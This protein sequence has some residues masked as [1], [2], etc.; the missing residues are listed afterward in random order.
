M[1]HLSFNSRR[2]TPGIVRF[3]FCCIFLFVLAALSSCNVKDDPDSLLRTQFAPE[4]MDSSH[5][6]SPKTYS[7]LHNI[8]PPLGVKPVIVAVEKIEEAEMGTY[9]DNLFDRFCEKEYSGNTF[10]Q[11][12]VLIVASKEPELIQVRVG[13][14]YAVYCRMRGS[15]AGAD[16]LAMQKETAARGIDEMCPVALKNV[17]E[18]IEGCRRLPWYK[19]FAL[20]ISFLHV[21]MIMEDLATPSE[22]FFSQF[23][24][25]PFLFLVGGIKR[26]CGSWLLSFLFIALA[27]TLAKNRAEGRIQAFIVRKAKAHSCDEA[28]Y[29]YTFMLFNNLQGIVLFLVKLVIAVPTFAAISLLSSSR[30]E[31]I[32]ALKHAHIPSVE[33]LDAATHW[34]NHSTGL[35]MVVVLMAVYYLKFLF[36]DKGGF[37]YGCMPDRIQQQAYRQNTAFRVA[38]DNIIRYGYN[39]SKI[40][41][42]G[43]QILGVFLNMFHQ[44]NFHEMTPQ[45]VD[46]NN[47]TETDKDGQPGKRLVDFL[48]LDSSAPLF[49]QA[50]CLAVQVNTHREALYLT[51]MVGFVATMMLSQ[52]YALYFLVLWMVQLALRVAGEYSAARK[53]SADYR[54]GIDPLRIFR[55][56]WKTDA[57]FLV[58]ACLVFFVIVPS[59]SPKTLDEVA[60]VRQS[61]PDDFTGLYFVTKADGAAEKGVTAR[62]ARKDAGN[63][64]MQVY[65]DKPVRRFALTLDT[66]A[67]MFHSDI[68]G[69]GY[70]TYDGQTKSITINFSDLWVLRN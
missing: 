26:V 38:M 70:I 40:W 47:T 29:A 50:P 10:R 35:W 25:R 31:D 51:A 12:G 45:H 14:T 65:S 48:F 28:D 62:L 3:L 22:S 27:Y 1:T 42:V 18:D 19:K 49:R 30:T 54:Q 68:L 58:A 61:L 23:Y 37:L 7:Y 4:V 39:R 59:Y 13:K 60:E 9:A 16:Y 21:D 56:V 6:L 17:V 34:T 43:K 2:T 53:M 11:R 69:D 66:E 57:V 24:F 41:M 32:I 52:T 36:C 5:V 8:T 64:L 55:R 33:L 44:Q 15:A 20:K 67:G 46:D 63:Y